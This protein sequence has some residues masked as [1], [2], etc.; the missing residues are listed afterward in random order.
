[1]FPY[2]TLKIPSVPPY[3]ATKW[4]CDPLWSASCTRGNFKSISEAIEWAQMNLDGRPYS[5]LLVDENDTRDALTNERMPSAAHAE[6]AMLACYRE[7]E[8]QASRE[9]HAS[10][11]DYREA[12]EFFAK[13]VRETK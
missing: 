7:A 3:L 12:G 6:L 8:S 13:L 4:H 5:I 2:F 1:M 9:R 10:A 11:S